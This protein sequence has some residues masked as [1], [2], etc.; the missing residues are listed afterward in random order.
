MIAVVVVAGSVLD[1]RSD[2]DSGKAQCLEVIELVDQALEV[3]APCRVA[4]GI[5]RLCVVPAVNVVA[6][7]AVI[8]TGG[9]DKVNGI[10]T[11]IGSVPLGDLIGIVVIPF[12]VLVPPFT[13][14]AAQLRRLLAVDHKQH[15]D[16]CNI[17]ERV[18]VFAVALRRHCRTGVIGYHVGRQ[19]VPIVDSGCALLAIVVDCDAAVAN[20]L[21]SLFALANVD[22]ARGDNADRNQHANSQHNCKTFFRCAINTPPYHEDNYTFI[23]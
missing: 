23:L 3:A 17:A 5:V 16:F 18:T 8:K 2:P 11:Q 15:V 9:N 10:L 4:F 22:R 13:G 20:R 7:V 21:G 6:G 1:D 12:V 14:G 19:A